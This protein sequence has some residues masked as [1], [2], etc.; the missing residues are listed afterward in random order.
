MCAERPSHPRQRTK[1]PAK[2]K[3]QVC[4][5]CGALTLPQSQ[6]PLSLK[7]PLAAKVPYAAKA[8]TAKKIFSPIRGIFDII[9]E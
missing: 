5:V 3:K 1:A 8:Q 6:H 9:Y 4:D 2:K 7:P